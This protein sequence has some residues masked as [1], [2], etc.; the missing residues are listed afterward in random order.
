MP[1]SLLASMCPADPVTVAWLKGNIDKVFG[2]PAIVR[3]SWQTTTKLLEDNA[4]P[5]KW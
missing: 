5:M 1:G 3:F 2:F 4:I